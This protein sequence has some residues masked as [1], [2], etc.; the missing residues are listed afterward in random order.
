[1]KPPDIWMRMGAYVHQDLLQQFPDL[2][3]GLIDFLSEEPAGQRVELQKYCDFLL[4]HPERIAAA[5]NGTD[6][7]LL[8]SPVG[9]KQLV[10]DVR[11]YLRTV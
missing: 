1:M 2:I 3:S 5:W 6:T 7:N 9:A 8:L 4:R 10:E 11:T